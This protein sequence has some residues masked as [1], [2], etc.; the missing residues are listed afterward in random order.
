MN[1]SVGLKRIYKNIA[2]HDNT[3]NT[4]NGVMVELQGI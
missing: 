2:N 1:N 4:S 3:H